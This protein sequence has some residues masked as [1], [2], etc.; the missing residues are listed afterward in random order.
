[1]AAASYLSMARPA[2]MVARPA[3]RRA[4]RADLRH[5]QL[6]QRRCVVARF[7]EQRREPAPQPADGAATLSMDFDDLFSRD[8]PCPHGAVDAVMR[9]GGGA[10]EAVLVAR[11]TETLQDLIPRLSKVT[12]LPV[13]GPNGAVVGVISRKDIIKVRQQGGSLQG[14]VRDHMSSPAIT[15]GPGTPVAEAG[16][17]M[18]Q[19]GIRRLPV[20]DADGKPLG[21]VSRSDIFTPL[22]REAYAAYSEREVVRRRF[23]APRAALRPWAPPP[24]P[25]A[26][27]SPRSSAPR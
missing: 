20:V 5:T 25:R 17:T 26:R 16:Q 24:R 2:G 14:R 15:V 12:G 9:G 6:P 18:L 27:A 8:A 10:G 1:M 4:P 21:I 3:A 13:V 19:H 23:A 11:P 7:R 22:M